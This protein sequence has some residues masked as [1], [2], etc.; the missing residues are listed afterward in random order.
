MRTILAASSLLLVLAPLAPAQEWA[1]KMFDATAHDF[2]T[3]ARGAKTEYRFKFKNLYEEEV[4]VA[5]VRSSCGCTTPQISKAA[6]K[7]FE[8]GEVLAEFNTR[9]FLGAKTATI[10][11]VFDKPFPAEVQLSVKGTIRGDVVLTPGEVNFGTVD[12]GT[13]AEQ[14]V[15]VVHQG[16][17][18]WQIVDARSANPYFEVELSETGRAKGRVAYDMLV[19]LTAGAPA[20]Y[21]NDQLTIVTNDPRAPEIVVTVEGR[22]AAAI[23]VSPA[24][25]YMGVVRPGEKVTK[26]LIVRGKQPFRI[27]DITCDDDCFEAHSG[28]EAR[29]MHVIPV[30]FKAGTKP[31]KVTRRIAIETDQQGA[32]AI[33]T[34]YALVQEAAPTDPAGQ[35]PAES[36][37]GSGS[38]SSADEAAAEADDDR[39]PRPAQPKAVPSGQEKVYTIPAWRPARKRAA[40]DTP[41]AAAD[42]QPPAGES[43]PTAP[44]APA[45]DAEPGPP[46]DA[47]PAAPSADEEP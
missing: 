14:H 1:R 41:P 39:K 4:H 24:A 2:G 26:R 44:P 46:D 23:S 47:E 27:V 10:T 40:S 13:R 21:L 43:Q 3:V 29:S 45:A 31:G 20:G 9:S 18:D 32:K 15:Q 25:L 37:A 6:L 19:R 28:D 36:A 38:D 12:V 42:P 11:V 17:N 5:S 22:L 30:V 7:T 33:F 35:S 34:A 16:R 8:T